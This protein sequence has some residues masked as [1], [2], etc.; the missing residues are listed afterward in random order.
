[1]LKLVCS[2]LRSNDP[3]SYTLALYYLF[4]IVLEKRRGLNK[5]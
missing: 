1:M 5:I 3:L 2:L 4:S